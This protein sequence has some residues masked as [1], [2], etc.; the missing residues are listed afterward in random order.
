[1]EPKKPRKTQKT[2]NKQEIDP[3]FWEGGFKT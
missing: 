3:F 1:M 2:Q